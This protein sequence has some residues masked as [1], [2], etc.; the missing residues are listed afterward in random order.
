MKFNHTLNIRGVSTKVNK[1][2]KTNDYSGSDCWK[3]ASIVKLNNIKGSLSQL[4]I[5][6]NEQVRIIHDI[7]PANPW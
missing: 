5:F 4:V 6:E 1:A 3:L 2:T 7:R